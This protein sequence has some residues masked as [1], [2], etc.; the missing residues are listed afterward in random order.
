MCR[1]ER[2][3]EVCIGHQRSPPGR[4]RPIV[5]C[6]RDAGLPACFQEKEGTREGLGC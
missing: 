1:R 2:E 4:A 3:R 5:M 6:D